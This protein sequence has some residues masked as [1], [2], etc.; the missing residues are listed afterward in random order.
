[1]S[2]VMRHEE[3]WLLLPWLANG[4]LSQAERVRVEE[5]VHGCTACATELAQQRLMCEALTEP[6]RVTYAPGPSF[7]KLVERIDGRPAAAPER[8]AP[9]VHGFPAPAL[10]AWRPP[11]LAFAAS[12][13]AVVGLAAAFAT[14]R[15]SQPLYVTHS[16]DVAR[17]PGVLHIA[18]VP[19]LPVGEAE[20][21]LR[22]AGARVVEGPDPSGIFGVTASGSTQPDARELR[23][24]AQRLHADTRVLWV[25]PLAAAATPAAVQEPGTR[26]R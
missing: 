15:W 8:R 9:R 2:A 10:S 1:M 26:E 14:A 25:E 24:L 3:S 13:V 22:T 18:F 12:F 6:D 19:S 7:R 20:E 17:A 5:H 11:G 21:L 16:D 4:R 23:S